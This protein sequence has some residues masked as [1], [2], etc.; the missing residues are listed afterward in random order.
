MIKTRPYF[1][2]LMHSALICP[3]AVLPVSSP[4]TSTMTLPFESGSTFSNLAIYSS[5]FAAV[6]EAASLIP[7]FTFLTA[8]S[9]LRYYSAK[10]STDNQ[11]YT[12]HR[13][14]KSDSVTYEIYHNG[15]KYD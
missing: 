15:E 2:K 8:L 13:K 10:I 11:M 1:T 12:N 14:I 7:V 4:F 5:K 6:N 9:V 3:S